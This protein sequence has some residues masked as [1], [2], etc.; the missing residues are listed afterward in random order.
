MILIKN[1]LIEI[2]NVFSF[3]ILV[4][5]NDYLYVRKLDSTFSVFEFVFFKGVAFSSALAALANKRGDLIS[6]C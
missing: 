3:G 2:E 1:Q 5:K 6:S 4:F